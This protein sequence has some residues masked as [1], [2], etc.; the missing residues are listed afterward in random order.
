MEIRTGHVRHSLY[1]LQT[2]ELLFNIEAPWFAYPHEDG[3]R[4]TT[5]EFHEWALGAMDQKI[6]GILTERLH[7]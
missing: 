1:D 7:N 3:E 6:Q 5:D 4:P 2:E